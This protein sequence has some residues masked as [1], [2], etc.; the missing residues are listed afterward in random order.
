MLRHPRLTLAVTVADDR[1][2]TSTSSSSCRRASSPSRTRAGSSGSIQAEQDISFPA[3]S[4]KLTRVRED[5]ARP[6]PPSP[7]SS[8]SRAAPGNPTNT[9]RM[10]VSLKPLGERKASRRPGHRPPARQARARPGR[11]AVPAGRAGPA[12][13]RPHEQRPV[14]VHAAERRP[15]RPESLGAAHARAS[16]ASCP[17]AR[18]DQR[19]AEPRAAGLARDRP[20]HRLAA[21]HLAADRSTTRSTTPSA[22]AR[23]RRSITPLN[24]YHV[25]LEVAPAVP[26]GPRRAQEH[27][28][29]LARGRAGAAERLRALRVAQHA[30]SPSTTRAS[31]RR[32]R[33]RS[34][35]RRGVALGE[36]VAAIAGRRARDRAC[37]RPCRPASRAPRRRS[38]PRSPIEP[39]L[40]LAAL[41]AVYIVLG[42]LYES[43]IHPIT[44]LSTLPSAGVGALLALLLFG[45]GPRAS[46][47]SS[48]SSC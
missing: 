47:P 26:A 14:P 17:A 24:Q 23:S 21:R 41:I 13:R 20:R 22:S 19:P 44:I 11:H 25:V 2:S 31:S 45:T 36:A 37:R 1:R 28:R 30:A 43:F 29:P 5:R 42:M 46:S 39:L 33:S 8:P 4:E 6:I 3:M 10:F 7:P 34:T 15:R 12:H 40:I 27:L 38:R 18:R 32:S 48:A 16:C 35:S 9:G